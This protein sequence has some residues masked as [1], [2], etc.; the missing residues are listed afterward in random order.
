MNQSLKLALVQ[1]QGSPIPDENLSVARDAAL[2]S[3]ALGADLVVFPEM[4]MAL[5][6]PGRGL[7]EVAEPLDGPFVGSL[8]ALASDC[9]L[10]IVAGVWESVPNEARVFN[11]A[12]MLSAQGESLAVYRKLHL[13]DA[14]NV[15][16]SDTM[17][18]GNSVP[19]IVTVK[20]FHIGFA[21]CHDL[22]FPELFRSLALRGASLIV[23]PSAWYSGPLKE[24]HYLTLLRARAIENTVYVGGADLTGGGF[25]GRTSLFDPY[26]VPVAG[27]G[28]GPALV[29]G[30]ISF[31]R[32]DDV[33]AKVPTL[34]Q[35]RVELFRG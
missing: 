21:I 14:L 26:G 12:I 34:R 2:R 4:F 17:I 16:E 6:V 32:L 13:F 11:S 9:K 18:P 15:K 30:E 24:D 5:P 7:T 31:A 23:V 29:V 33:R 28:E 27:A 25:C 22:R 3:A 20:G 35:C 19:P 1:I 10:N 8:A